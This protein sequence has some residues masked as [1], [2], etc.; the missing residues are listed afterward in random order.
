MIENTP[1]PPENTVGLPAQLDVTQH[2][3]VTYVADEA[4]QEKIAKLNHELETRHPLLGRIQKGED[5]LQHFATLMETI[6]L[7]AF[8][9]GKDMPP[10]NGK[11]GFKWDFEQAKDL[12]CHVDSLSTMKF[13]EILALPITK[14]NYRK[15]LDLFLKANMVKFKDEEPNETSYYYVIV[16]LLQQGHYQEAATIADPIR[17]SRAICQGIEDALTLSSEL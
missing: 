4:M 16:S 6:H 13:R 5:P 3:R 11:T 8:L 15:V 1:K 12:A 17:D 14:E 7:A 10:P 2:Y 9:Q